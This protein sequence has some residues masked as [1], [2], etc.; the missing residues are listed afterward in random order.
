MLPKVNLGLALIPQLNLDLHPSSWGRGDEGGMTAV[1][2]SRGDSVSW[3]V[4]F[5]SGGICGR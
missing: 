5:W 3:A 1:V 4:L 2:S